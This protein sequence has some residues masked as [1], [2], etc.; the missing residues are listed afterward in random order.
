MHKDL[1][2]LASSPVLSEYNSRS[3]VRFDQEPLNSPTA[4]KTQFNTPKSSPR[5]VK[6][7]TQ[8]GTGIL[9]PV[10]NL[11]DNI[12][13]PTSGTPSPQLIPPQPIKRN[14]FTLAADTKTSF[15]KSPPR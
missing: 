5:L 8:I 15:E 13:S 2:H 6:P 11:S 14:N 9:P 12:P 3:P 4:S 10:S 1:R 7:V